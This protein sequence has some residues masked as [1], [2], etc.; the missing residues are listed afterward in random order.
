MWIEMSE[1][2]GQMRGY[3][4]VIAVVRV[5]GQLLATITSAAQ[6]LVFKLTHSLL[7]SDFDAI[8]IYPILRNFH[9]YWVNIYVR[10]FDLALHAINLL[11]CVDRDVR[12]ELAWRP[13][14]AY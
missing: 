8:M 6:K 13:R 9:R 12:R 2:A 5:V 3:K 7:L 1:L 4:D 11:R 10:C 14:V